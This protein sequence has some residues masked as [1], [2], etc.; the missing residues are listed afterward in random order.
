MTFFL[1]VLIAT[2]GNAGIQSATIII[3]SLAIGDIGVKDFFNV[4]LRES[5]LGIFI[6]GTLALVGLGRAVFQ[7]FIHGG[8]TRGDWLLSFSV[9]ISMGIT[10]VLAAIVGASLPLIS[11]RFKL[12]PALMSGPLITTVVDV[13]GILVYFEIAK[14][15]LKL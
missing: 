15:I 10:V 6:G 1:P 2:G 7:L 11:R 13:V 4:I 12:D 14:L 8:L 5:L 3:R 9:G